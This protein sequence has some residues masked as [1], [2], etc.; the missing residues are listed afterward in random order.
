M[1]RRESIKE[2]LQR[3]LGA[4]RKKEDTANLQGALE[5]ILQEPMKALPVMGF[6]EDDIIPI[7]SDDYVIVGGIDTDEDHII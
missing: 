2:R 1:N 6:S 3:K 5:A 7:P 4:R